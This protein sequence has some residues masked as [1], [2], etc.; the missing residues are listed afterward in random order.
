[1]LYEVWLKEFTKD[2]TLIAI[3]DQ[4]LIDATH[5]VHRYIDSENVFWE[6][7]ITYGERVVVRQGKVSSDGVTIDWSG[8]E[9]LQEIQ[10]QR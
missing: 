10:I 8:W 4:S 9:T 3:L 2:K 6:T 5:D 7:A 1:M